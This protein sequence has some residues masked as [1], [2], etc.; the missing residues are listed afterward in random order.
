MSCA[1]C[2]Q[3]HQRGVT[4]AGHRDLLAARVAGAVGSGRYDSVHIS[5]FGAE[6]LMAYAVIRDLSRRFTAVTDAAGAVYSSTMVTNGAL[7]DA[8]K[9]AV[10]HGECRIGNFEVTLDGPARAHD[11]SRTLKRGG[12]S[13]EHIVGVI[14]AALDNPDLSGLTW[15]I[16]TNVGLHNA[17]LAEEFAE[18]VA[19]AG[20]A[21]QRVRFYPAP[22]HPWGNDVSAMALDRARMAEIE[23]DW[24]AAYQRHGLTSTLLPKA[25]KRVVCIAVT[26]HAEVVAPDG[27]VYSCTEQPLVPAF[28]DR[29]LGSL[30]TL[31]GDRRPTGDFDD[32]AD[33][34]DADETGCRSC[35]ILPLCGGACPKLWR[36][37]TPP[38]PPLR[39]NVTDR[40]DLYARAA[41][42]T[43][44]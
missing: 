41:G 21:D 30:D 42:C 15:R 44:V 35:R 28:A 10:L 8:R 25:P 31:V 18:V 27:G 6:P 13:F 36:E 4:G 17:G 3:A 2:G 29:R 14:R 39:H 32:W 43:P 38:C 11:A 20:L 7:L 24:L 33:A 1:Y 16:R 40:L 26:P 5:W 9:L 34:L 19:A 23:L 22:V 12:G 37:G